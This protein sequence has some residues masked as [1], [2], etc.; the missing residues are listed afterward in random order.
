MGRGISQVLGRIARSPGGLFGKNEQARPEERKILMC[1]LCVVNAVLLAAGATSGGGAGAFAVNRFLNQK[2]K[3]R[4]EEG[5]NETS[6]N[7]NTENRLTAGVGSCA[8]TAAR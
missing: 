4:T 1:P 2:R 5:K 3:Y 6:E 7:G 8:P